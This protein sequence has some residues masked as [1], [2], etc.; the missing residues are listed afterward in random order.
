MDHK[1]I[2]TAVVRVV[3]AE[4][5]TT[6]GGSVEQVL[7]LYPSDPQRKPLKDAIRKMRQDG[8]QVVMLDGHSG[9][10]KKFEV[11]YVSGDFA[12][13]Q[14]TVTQCVSDLMEA[15]QEVGANER[16]SMGFTLEQLDAPS[17]PLPISPNRLI[18]TGIGIGVGV[19][20]AAAWTCPQ[21]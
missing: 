13:A 5:N 11:Q 9:E 1:Y 12:R 4:E 7:N 18:I 8:V 21:F 15:N 2:S 20:L 6:V 10:P 19:L 14:K 16:S 17:R 3:S